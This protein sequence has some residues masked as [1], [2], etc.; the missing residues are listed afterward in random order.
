MNTPEDRRKRAQ[1]RLDAERSF[2]IH[3]L[4]YVLVNAFLAILNYSTKPNEI[5]FSWPLLGW[6][7]GLAIHGVVTFFRGRFPGKR[8]EER[9]MKQLMR[10][11]DRDDGQ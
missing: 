4:V 9:R 10:E 11:E 7:I 2:Y 3:V 8:W 5:W 6:G 1:D